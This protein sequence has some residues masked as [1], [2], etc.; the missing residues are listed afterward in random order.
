VDKL[1]LY[2]EFFVKQNVDFTSFEK[3]VENGKTDA[4]IERM[5]IEFCKQHRPKALFNAGK[6][7]VREVFCDVFNAI[8]FEQTHVDFTSKKAFSYYSFKPLNKMRIV[9]APTKKAAREIISAIPYTALDSQLGNANTLQ[10][11]VD[12]KEVDG[13]LTFITDKGEQRTLTD[14]LFYTIVNIYGNGVSL[15]EQR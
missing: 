9:F 13:Q 3:A 5:V 6:D 4:F 15:N 7:R 1:A 8:F 2:M 11:I 10:R 14:P 12:M